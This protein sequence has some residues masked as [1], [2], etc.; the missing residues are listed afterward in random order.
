MNTQPPKSQGITYGV[1]VTLVICA[2][3][4]WSFM[5]LGMRHIEL[6]NVWQILLYRSMSLCLFLFVVITIRS[7]GAPFKAIHRAGRSSVI[8]A[9]GLLLAFSCSIHSIQTTTVA[10]AMFLFAAAPFFAA[11][12]GW[13]LLREKVRIGTWMATLIAAL[14][15]LVMVL[16]G[17]SAGYMAG[18]ITALLSALGF[19]IF[20]VSLRWG[21]QED[22]LPAVFLAGLF[23]VITALA[24]CFYQGYAVLLINQDGGIALLLG[25]FQ[26]GLGLTLYTVGSKVVPAVEL[27]MLS[28]TEVLLGPLWVWLLL[29]EQ[30]SQYTFIGGLILLVAIIINAMTGL[31]RKPT[32]SL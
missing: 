9:C 28:M 2:G 25:V 12:L 30:M 5:G 21:K 15:V 10:N 23:A 11:L 20:T 26:L 19:A 7:G 8:G 32:P 14:G 1:G 17:I 29:D 31:R 13:V 24:V 22:M 6:A 18:N 27:A 3:F 16:D 4:F